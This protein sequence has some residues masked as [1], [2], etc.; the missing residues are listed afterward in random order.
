MGGVVLVIHGLTYSYSY[1]YQPSFLWPR[2]M[3]RLNICCVCLRLY[4]YLCVS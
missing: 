2:L 3:H 4:L 1:S